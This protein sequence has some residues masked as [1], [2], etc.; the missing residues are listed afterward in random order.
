M[1]F[2]NLSRLLSP[3]LPQRPQ[4]CLLHLG[5]GIVGQFLQ[6]GHGLA[7]LQF[8]AGPGGFVAQFGVGFEQF[9]PYLFRPTGVGAA[10]HRKDGADASL[11]FRRGVGFADQICHG[12]V[13]DVGQRL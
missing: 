5:I 13:V 9:L 1:M 12:L 11:F 3:N 6:F 4:G 2:Q 10:S 8:A 7:E